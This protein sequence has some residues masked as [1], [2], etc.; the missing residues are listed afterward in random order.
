MRLLHRSNFLYRGC[1]TSNDCMITGR[2]ELKI[3]NY[4]FNDIKNTQLDFI[5]PPNLI[6]KQSSSSNVLFDD[7]SPS[8]EQVAQVW[9][10]SNTL[11][12]LAP[13][14]VVAVHSNVYITFPNKPTDVYG[15]GII[16]T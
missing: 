5:D 8:H 1:L 13:E 9:R 3:S 7:V 6:R 2:W 11:L 12:W 4:G 10:S 14:S 15:V 16:I